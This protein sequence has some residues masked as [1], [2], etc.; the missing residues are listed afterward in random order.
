VLTASEYN[1]LPTDEMVYRRF[2]E[3]ESAD[4]QRAARKAVQRRDWA[5]VQEML[6]DIERRAFDNPWLQSTVQMLKVLLS[7]RDHGRMEKELMYSSHQMKNR[8]APLQDSVLFCMSTE[9]EIPAF[10]RRKMA[11]GRNTD[12]Q[13]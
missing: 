13:S 8:S 9:A 6:D 10:L 1:A 4:L 11:Q 3:V 2:T 12:S 5:Q 7:N